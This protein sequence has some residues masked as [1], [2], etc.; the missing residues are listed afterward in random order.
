MA[1]A[2]DADPFA[3]AASEGDYLLQLGDRLRLEVVLG[4]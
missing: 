3:E 1:I 2:G 4:A